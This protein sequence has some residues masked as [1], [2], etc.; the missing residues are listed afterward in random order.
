MTTKAKMDQQN[1]RWIS[2][3]IQ[4]CLKLLGGTTKKEWG[5]Y[6]ISIES[7]K[8]T[9]VALASSFMTAV[10]TEIA[11]VKVTGTAMKQ[12]S[13]A[14]AKEAIPGGGLVCFRSE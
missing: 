6:R 3:K 8:A 7:K 13:G 1:F 4:Q 11:T 10:M 2:I 12:P 5:W 14:P 9:V